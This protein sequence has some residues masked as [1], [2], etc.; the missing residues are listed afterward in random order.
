M[1]SS[2]KKCRRLCWASSVLL[3]GLLTMSVK[4]AIQFTE[5]TDD[6]GITFVHTN[7]ASGK[8]HIVETVAAGLA[9]FD[10]DNDKDI[11]IY[12][13]NG[14]YHD[15]D[16]TGKA[17]RNTLYRN[18]GNWRFVDVTETAGV[19]DQGYGLGVAVADYDND[20]DTDIY[21]NN[22]GPNVLYRNNG[23]GTFTDV[24]KSAGLD[25]GPHMGAGAS[26]LDIDKDGDLDLFVAHYVH[27]L[28]EPAAPAQ[29]G[30]R[31]AYLGPAVSIYRNTMDTLYRNN[32]DGTFTDISDA[33]G[34]TTEASAGMGVICGDYD[35][36]GD[37]D[38]FVAS[39]MSG[40]HLFLN[41][42]KGVFEEF[43][44]FAGVAYDHHGEEQGSMGLELADT[45]NDGW[46]DLYLTSYQNQWVALYQNLGDGT[47][48]DISLKSGASQ[49]SFPKVTW[50]CGLVDFDNDGDRDI[51]V[52]CGHLQ[53]HIEH[54]DNRST[55][56]QLNI[57]YE[58]KGAGHYTNIS[59]HAG[60]G[61]QVNRVSRGAG[62][63]DLDG[64]GDIDVVIL[65]SCDKPTLLRNDTPSPGHWLQVQL[66]GVQT[67]RD[68]VGAQ[69]RVF[70]GDLKLLD[71]VHSGRSYQ[72]DFGKRLYFGLGKQTKIDR[73][74]VAWIGG[75]K[76]TFTVD[77][78]DRHVVLVEGQ[79]FPLPPKA[80]K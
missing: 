21:L 45:N 34:I 64:D 72:S 28:K 65:N 20:G 41:D 3:G 76:E 16:P 38:I 60:T 70:A 18:D 17:P 35:N 23:D 9:L 11:D 32:G 49:G 6:S 79:G 57:L 74:E 15:S 80:R 52:A 19:G 63:D 26:F 50:G 47:F 13:L 58:N 73:V 68:G 30:G 25:D 36:D 39:D 24:T 33:S 31:P 37:T 43:A 78:V 67:N 1:K 12:F 4:G 66:R 46:L 61:L 53:P 48:D 7:G 14:A 5:V 59:E 44:L 42:G 27:C 8:F 62:F 77:Q 54:Y 51:F 56:R 29:R 55:Y 71:E 10:Y 69:V 40:N 22:Y 2:C 75:T